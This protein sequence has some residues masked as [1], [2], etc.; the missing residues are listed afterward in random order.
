MTLPSSVYPSL[1]SPHLLSDPALLSLS[2]STLPS[3]PQWPCPP[4]SIPLYPHLTSLV[5]LPSSFYPS[6]PSPSPPQWPCPPQSIPFSPPPHLLSDPA[7]L[8]LSLSPLTS[9]PQWPCPPQSIP[10]SPPPHLL[11]DP[12]LLIPSL[13]PPLT[14]SVTLPSSVYPSL[15]SPSPPQ[16]P[17]PPQSIPLYPP[18]TSSVTLPSSVYP[19]HHILP[20]SVVGHPFPSPPENT[21]GSY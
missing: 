16:W 18:L 10:F 14:S 20:S 8:S 12:A 11:S 3:P 9:P 19:S 6:L 5:T 2:L 1:P 17:C 21:Q 4:Q 7:L 15:P 13:Y